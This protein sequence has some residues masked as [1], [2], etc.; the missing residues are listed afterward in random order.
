MGMEPDGMRWGFPE[1]Q[2]DLNE[3]EVTIPTKVCNISLYVSW[4]PGRRKNI[5]Q[6]DCGCSF[7]HL[8]MLRLKN[9]CS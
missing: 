1:M 4:L 2:F 5:S 6:F 9:K 7:K 8:D 3:R